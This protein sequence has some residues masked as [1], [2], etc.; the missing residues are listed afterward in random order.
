MRLHVI[1]FNIPYPADYGGVIDVYER[2]KA[3][4]AIG[5]EIALHAFEYG[6]AHAPIL[7]NFCKEVNYYPRHTGILAQLSSKPYIVQSRVAP[8]LLDRLRSDDDPILL[9]GIHTSG[10]LGKLPNERMYLRAHNVEHKYYS[11]LAE[12]QGVGWR[13]W[14]HGME[15]RKL[16]KYEQDVFQNFQHVFAISQKDA[17]I[18]SGFNNNTSVIGPFH[19]WSSQFEKSEGV[20]PKYALYQG[21]L[22]VQENVQIV[23]DLIGE[24]FVDDKMRFIIAGKN[25]TASLSAKVSKHP[26]VS[27]IP[28]PTNDEMHKLMKE[29]HVHVLPAMQETGLK[30]KLLAAL[31]SNQ[32]V[33]ANHSMAPTKELSEMCTA[34][35]S[36]DKF[37]MHLDECWDA[38]IKIEELERRKSILSTKYSNQTNAKAIQRII[39]G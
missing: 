15:A 36:L 27:I 29:A 28:N 39:F 34:V 37:R 21:D 12:I 11:R 4:H 24:A 9:E 32:F 26:W 22:S 33:I 10:I 6:R 19:P 23:L 2:L 38:N 16:K 1:S 3:L 18:I 25:P 14:Y 8:V 13:K 35:C 17:E 20:S 5:I 30:L 31:Y 7:N